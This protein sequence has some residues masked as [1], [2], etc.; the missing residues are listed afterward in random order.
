[1]KRVDWEDGLR[2]DSDIL[3]HSD[4]TTAKNNNMSN[5]LPHNLRKGISSFIIDKE[6]LQTG[7]ISIKNIE[8]FLIDKSFVSFDDSYPLSLQ[9][10][11]DETAMVIPV[12]LNVNEKSKEIDG[13]K[14]IVEN[15]TLSSEY[16]HVSNSSIK[17]AAFRLNNLLLEPIETDYPILSMNHYLMDIVFSKLEKLVSSMEVFA[18]FTFSASNP[19]ASIYLS[20]LIKKLKRELELAA[21]NKKNISPLSLFQCV[22]DIYISLLL[23]THLRVSLLI[24][25]T[26]LINHILH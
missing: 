19:L 14:Y 2:L 20:F 17:I 23:I 22:H 3:I 1:M 15:L 21:N 26:I 24:F 4:I 6:N 13:V 18:K 11:F 10:S 9:I 7:L 12:F 25:N 8:I 5:I 16:N